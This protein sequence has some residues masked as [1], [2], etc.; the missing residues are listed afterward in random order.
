M[1]ASI[2]KQKLNDAVRTLAQVD[3]LAAEAIL[4]RFGAVNTVTL[5]QDQWQAVCDAFEAALKGAGREVTPATLQ[6]QGRA[7]TLVCRPD[8]SVDEVLDAM[9]AGK[10]F[11]LKSWPGTRMPRLWRRTTLGY[12]PA[13]PSRLRQWL[14]PIVVSHALAV[15]VLDSDL[16][17]FPPV[18]EVSP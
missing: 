2:S 18:P 6:D 11:Y 1:S 16:S 9:R 4:K 14:K 15:K 3:R 8:T 13:T 17:E 7:E 5:P 12:E 10:F